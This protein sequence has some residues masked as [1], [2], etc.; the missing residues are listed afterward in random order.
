MAAL[1]SLGYP[2]ATPEAHMDAITWDD[3]FLVGIG[4]IDRQH[5][6][7]IKLINRLLIVHRTGGSEILAK[8]MLT[9]LIAY[10]EYHFVSEENIMFIVQYD[11]LDAQHQ[12]HEHLLSVLRDKVAGYAKHQETLEN[13]L[14]YLLEWFIRHTTT[15]D[16]K[17][18]AH[19]AHK[20]I[21]A[22]GEHP[23]DAAAP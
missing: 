7:F 19:A 9:E 2:D 17:I 4:E 15:E 10:A 12:E 11:G 13:L 22:D 16:R 21:G 3:R 1:R 6:D 8:R 5:R 14:T 20:K 23:I 18:G